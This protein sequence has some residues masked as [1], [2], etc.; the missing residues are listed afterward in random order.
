MFYDFLQDDDIVIYQN[1]HYMSNYYSF[2]RKYVRVEIKEY[3][4]W[5]TNNPNYI[6]LH[7]NKLNVVLSHFLFLT[8]TYYET[9]NWYHIAIYGLSL[10]YKHLNG[11]SNW[12]LLDLKLVSVTLCMPK[13]R[14][15]SWSTYSNCLLYIITWFAPHIFLKYN[16]NR[17][18]FSQI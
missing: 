11:L 2:C 5:I 14:H 6:P 4:K 12:H 1:R 18:R 15:S 9:Q 13:N 3:D 10:L 17:C 8:L 7:Q 16:K